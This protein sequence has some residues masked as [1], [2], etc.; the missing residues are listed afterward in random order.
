MSIQF[1][2]HIAAFLWRWGES[3]P[4][5]N[6]WLIRFLQVYL[7]FL[8][9]QN[10]G[11]S[12]N[13]TT[14][15]LEFIPIKCGVLCCIFYSLR[16]YCKFSILYKVTSSLCER[17]TDRHYVFCVCCFE[18]FLSSLIQLL[19]AYYTTQP[20]CQSQASPIILKERSSV[21]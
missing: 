11:F 18:P 4:R 15:S 14:K 8:S 16:Y 12:I 17:S 5:P 10:I 2:Q 13:I 7:T 3:N 9:Q 20:C 1:V 6:M 19:L 21:F